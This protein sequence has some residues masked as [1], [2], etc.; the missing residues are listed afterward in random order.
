MSLDEQSICLLLREGI[1]QID[2]IVDE[3]QIPAGRALAALTL[4]EV[5][6]VVRRLPGRRFALA[7]AKNT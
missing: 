6:G 4:L 1:R 5:K 7:Q 3:A 2:N